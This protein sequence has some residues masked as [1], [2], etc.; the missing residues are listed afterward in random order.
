MVR[1]AG[2][3]IGGTVARIVA[4]H[5][6]EGDIRGQQ[7]EARRSVRQQR[8]K[9]LVNEL[10]TWLESQLAAVSRKSTSA[11]AS[12]ARIYRDSFVQ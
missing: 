8:T 5:A 4:I 12:L 2:A 6:I 9:P 11:E 10:K 7:A 1:F 3:V